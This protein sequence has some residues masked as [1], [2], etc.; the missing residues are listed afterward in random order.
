MR[1]VADVGALTLQGLM[2]VGHQRVQLIRQRLQ[3]GRIDGLQAIGLAP[4]H[5]PHLAAQIEQRPQSY[6]HLDHHRDDQARAQQHKRQG[7]GGDEVADVPINGSA[8]LSRQEDKRASLQG[9]QTR[10]RAQPFPRQRARRIERHEVAGI[11]AQPRH[12][13]G[14]GFQFGVPQRA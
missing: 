9:G 10:H 1:Q 13:V 5:I 4:A 6:P 12:Q 3:F 8:V 2:I 14:R 7:G 11:G